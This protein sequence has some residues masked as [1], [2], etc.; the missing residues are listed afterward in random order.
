M[1]AYG[2][3]AKRSEADILKFDDGRETEGGVNVERTNRI[4]VQ[5]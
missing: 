5:K 2:H 4:N 3:T 1:N